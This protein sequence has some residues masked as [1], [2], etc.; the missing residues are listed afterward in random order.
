LLNSRT[1]KKE[2]PGT[3]FLLL[4]CILLLTAAALPAAAQIRLPCAPS[5]RS[6]PE[7]HGQSRKS[8]TTLNSNPL[9]LDYDVKFY[10]L[11]VEADDQSDHIQGN[12]T[13]LARV[14]NNPLSEFVVELYDGL[15]VDRVLVNGQEMPFSHAGNEISI[16]LS[17]PLGTDEMLEAQIFYGGKTGG[18]MVNEIDEYWDI[19]VTSTLSEPFYAK[20][21]FPCKENLGDKA[22]SVHVFITTDYGLMAASNG[23]LTGTTY[24]PNG[25]VRYEWKSRYPID[26][27]LISIAVADYIEY[28]IEAHPAGLSSPILIQN[29]L[30]D[31]PGC[32]ETCRE[33]INVTVPIME[34]YCDLFGPYPFREEKY[35][36]YMW[37]WGGGMEHQTMTGMGTFEFSY[38]AHELG[39][40]WFG[41][42]VTCA[43]WQDIWINEGFATFAGYL[44]TE[45]L[46]P[47]YAAGER[48]YRFESAM[49]EPDGSV[50]V[51]AGEADNDSRLFNFSLSYNKGMALL[52]MIRFELQDDGLF[53]RTLRDYVARYA[54][55]VATGMD[56]RQVLEE[57]SGMDFSGFFDQ[58]YFGAGY[59]IYAI[60]WEQ[61]DQTLMLTSTQ[62][63][64]SAITTLF[65]MPMEYRLFYPGGDTTVRV[66]QSANV[67][68]YTF[69]IPHAVDSIQID[70][71]DHV[72]NG[73]A[74]L[75][76]NTRS[77][78]GAEMVSVYPNPNDGHLSF[79]LIGEAGADKVKERSE[80]PSEVRS[81]NPS[82]VRSGNPSEVRSGNPSEV[83][84]GNPSEVRS[85]D[86]SEFPS[87]EQ[88]ADLIVE[89]FNGLGQRVYVRRF[90]G[91]V[92]WSSYSIELGDLARGICFVRFSYGDRT[93]IKKIIVE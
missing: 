33:L 2:I 76:G 69:D 32:L 26:F 54:G 55:N 40:S 13:I 36:H 1:M 37:P 70:P 46:A 65:R 71:D 44:A 66:Y 48:T 42:Y 25:K 93:E 41:D 78:S 81:G 89:V 5:F 29:F 38:V 59:P 60:D 88:R 57:T 49:R 79:R 47:E 4:L 84:S 85:A 28:D 74:G 80:D 18:G 10:K 23:I 52:Y 30:Y 56:F 14:R 50:Y 34:L 91:C 45:N 16:P 62:T 8:L 67:K 68:T 39:H 31:R 6:L 9:L 61:Q 35:G 43:T 51:P 64:S 82:E 21:W 90:G 73:V 12:V 19:P 3:L 11:D 77:K 22:D 15:V 83:R 20:D 87:G 86:P 7:V 75:K 24:F 58:W 53:F 17:S 27:Y 92:P 63:T 72:L